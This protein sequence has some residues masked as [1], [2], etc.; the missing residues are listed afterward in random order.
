[1]DETPLW[2]PSPERI[3]RS[4]VMAF[5]ADV[6]RRHS[7]ALRTYRDLHAWSI[8]YPDLFWDLVWDFSGVIGE[9]GPRRM[10]DG[11]KM[12]GAQFFPDARLNFA[13][14]LLR[15]SDDGEAMVF[16][17]EDKRTYRLSFA[18]LNALVSRLQQ[19]LQGACSTASA[20]SSPRC[21]LRSM[22]IGTTVNRSGS[23]TNSDPSFQSCRPRKRW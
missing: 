8:T 1:M 21:S 3:A 13:E 18:E 5:M 12:P 22:V 10:I 2:T 7:L 14:N 4:Q 6:N 19:A 15:R 23:A 16:R 20:R 9:K 11:E 17:G